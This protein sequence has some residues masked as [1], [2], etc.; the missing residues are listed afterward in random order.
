MAEFLNEIR[1]FEDA[2]FGGMAALNS[3]ARRER[4]KRDIFR[5]SSGRSKCLS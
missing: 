4:R 5:D 2:F 1:K 3:Y